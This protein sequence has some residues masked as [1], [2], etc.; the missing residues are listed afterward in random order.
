MDV[1]DVPKRKETPLSF[2]DFVV[3]EKQQQGSLRF[4]CAAVC[5]KHTVRVQSGQLC[6]IDRIEQ[7]Y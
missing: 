3:V 6:V 5:K 2:R 4:Y 7:A 1:S